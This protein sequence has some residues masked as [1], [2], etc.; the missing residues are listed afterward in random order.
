MHTNSPRQQLNVNFFQAVHT[1]N[2]LLPLV[3]NGQQ[4]K[5]IYISSGIGDI[6]TTRATELLGLVGYAISKAA[7]N[8]VIAKFGA[9]LKAKGISTLSLSPGWVETDAGECWLTVGD[10]DAC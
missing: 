5:I 8:I 9:E 6:P 10:S 2:A 4:K 7:G 3:E 1:I